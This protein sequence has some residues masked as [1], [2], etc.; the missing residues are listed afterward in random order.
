MLADVRFLD[1]SS[2]WTAPY[3]PDHWAVEWM[4]FTPN[5]A[6][7]DDQK[8]GLARRNDV[9]NVARAADRLIGKVLQAGGPEPTHLEPAVWKGQLFKV[10]HHQRIWN[11]LS[12]AEREIFARCVG[13]TVAEIEE[14]FRSVLHRK[15]QTGRVTGY[16][17]AAH[18]LLDAV[19]IGLFFYKRIARQGVARK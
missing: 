19:G 7:Q 6:S 14:K 4:V 9:M 3:L 11:A 1:A 2:L 12:P 15:V 10:L 17:W 18:N 13:Y 16:E 5:D 8:G